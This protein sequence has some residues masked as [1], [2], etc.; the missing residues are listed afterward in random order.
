MTHTK[1]LKHA[2]QTKVAQELIN[3]IISSELLITSE[4]LTPL[5]AGELELPKPLKEI[6]SPFGM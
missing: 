6:L 1:K 5:T 4:A 2:K 3:Y